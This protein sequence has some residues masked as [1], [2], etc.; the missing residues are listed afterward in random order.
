MPGF[1]GSVPDLC[2]EIVSPSNRRGDI[3]EKVADYLGGGARM[4]WVIDPQR[5]TGEVHRQGSEP[6]RLGSSDMLEGYGVVPGFRTP[7]SA[8][9][10]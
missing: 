5:R 2:V 6:V 10:E 4:V 1:V 7:L 3:A 9:F 8:L